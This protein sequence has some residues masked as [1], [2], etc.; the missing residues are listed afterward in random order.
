MFLWLPWWLVVAT[1]FRKPQGESS[2]EMAAQ[3]LGQSQQWHPCCREGPWEVD[4]WQYHVLTVPEGEEVGS[5]LLRQ[6]SCV[7]ADGRLTAE[8]LYLG[9]E[10]KGL[11]VRAPAKLES[12][13]IGNCFM[14]LSTDAICSFLEAVGAHI[15]LPLEARSMCARP[16]LHNW[17]LTTS[18]QPHELPMASFL[19]GQRENNSCHATC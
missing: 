11:R 16:E 19:S 5:Q 12:W 4:G 9:C 1:G 3:D 14:I 8:A 2:W 15:L 10:V 7:E 18:A 6:S 13:K 17:P